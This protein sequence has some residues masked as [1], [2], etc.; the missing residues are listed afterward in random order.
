M[1]AGF[2]ACLLLLLLPHPASA[3]LKLCNRTSYVLQTA[4]STIRNTDSLTRGWT[5]IIPGDCTTVVKGRLT[6]SSYLV[7]ARSALAHA[8]PTRAWGGAFPVCVKDGDF[9]LHQTVT[10]AYCTAADT[11]ALPFAPVNLKDRSD[12]TMDFDESPAL[13][14][15]TAAQLAGVKRLLSDNGY[16]PGAIDGLPSKATEA[17]LSDF[18]A[19]MKFTPQDGNDMLFAALEKQAGTK[20]A[21][22]GYAVCND[23]AE[24]LL[25]AIAETGTGKPRS[26]GW[27]RI[28]PKSCARAIT[29]P[30]SGPV[31]LLAQKLGGAVVVGGPEKF[32]T[33]SIAFEV[34]G[35]ADCATR[36]L[37]ESGF[38]TTAGGGLAGFVAHV[39]AAGLV[40]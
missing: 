2:Y 22:Q 34:V 13:V 1:R 38:A 5:R 25:A 23:S 4:T 30:L 26:R 9:V 7:Y 6:A 31:Y 11:F 35:R 12:W 16:K 27:W 33:T 17:A 32:C 3:D 40:R 37:A 39:G 36:G 29:T 8:G 24:P 20:S 21:P 19:K 18:R 15:L 28:A 14:S 10:Q